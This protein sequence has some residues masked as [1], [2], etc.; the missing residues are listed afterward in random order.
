MPL[1]VCVRRSGYSRGLGS[2][3]RAVYNEYRTN[4]A[5]QAKNFSIFLKSQ[6]DNKKQKQLDREG[7]S[8]Q[9]AARP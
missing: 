6:I 4:R 7:L 3:T 9:V 2:K 8:A 5:H 1:P